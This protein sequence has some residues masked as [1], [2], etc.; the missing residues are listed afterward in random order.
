M[1][2]TFAHPT[3]TS[4]A[5]LQHLVVREINASPLADAGLLAEPGDALSAMAE[6][7]PAS[8][9]RLWL[10]GQWISLTDAVRLTGRLECQALTATQRTAAI[11]CLHQMTAAD[12]QHPEFFDDVNR[13]QP[14]T[15]DLAE[16]EALMCS[17]PS[18]DLQFFFHGIYSARL[19]I[20]C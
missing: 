3:P 15:C 1:N 13:L 12:L 4:K 10:M 19:A 6:V 18:Q 2:T 11:Q 7:D 14:M 8:P 5:A 9:L 16:I 20:H 17:A